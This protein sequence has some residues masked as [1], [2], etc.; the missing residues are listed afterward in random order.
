MSENDKLAENLSY[1]EG[2]QTM[3]DLYQL[4]HNQF[5][6]TSFKFFGEWRMVNVAIANDTFCARQLSKEET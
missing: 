5:D 2:K 4:F 1:F 3:Q 6:Q